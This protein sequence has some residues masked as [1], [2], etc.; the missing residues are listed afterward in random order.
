VNNE[1]FHVLHSSSG[2]ITH[3]MIK[4]RKIRW[5][6]REEYK[7]AY[8]ILFGMSEGKKPLRRL[9]H[10]CETCRC[11]CR[12]GLGWLLDSLTL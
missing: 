11:S 5:Q 6:G 4:S 12:Q 7:N 2:I 3:R 1:E 9:R 8:S 10:R